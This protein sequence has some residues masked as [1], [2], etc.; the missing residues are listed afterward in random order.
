MTFSRSKDSLGFVLKTGTFVF[1]LVVATKV[2]NFFKKILIG[3]LFGIS[4]Q[5]DSFFAAS[6]LPYYVAVFFEGVIYLGVIP[7]FGKA[8]AEEGE[9]GAKRLVGEILPWIVLLTGGLVLGACLGAPWLVREIVPGFRTGSQTLTQNLFPVMSL[10][11]I[12][13][14][15]SSFFQ[16][17][18]SFFGNYLMAASSGLTDSLTMMGITLVT[19]SIWGIYGAAWG[20]VA[21]ALAAFSLQAFFL[22]RSGKIFPI[23]MTLRRDPILKLSKIL[24][25]LGIIWVFQ[26]I[27]LVILNRFGSGMWQ[28]TISAISISLGIMIVPTGLVSQTVLIS[29]F[30]SLVKDAGEVSNGNARETFF[31]TL[32]AAFFVLVPAGFRLSALAKPFAFLFFSGAGEGA[33]G[34]RRISNSLFYLGWSAFAFYADLFMTQSLITLRKTL[35]AI[36]LCATRAC[37]TYGFCYF[38]SYVW[39]YQGLALSFSLGLAVNLFVLFPLFFRMTPL[40]GMWGALVRYCLKLLLAASPLLVCGWFLKSGCGLSGMV[41]RKAPAFGILAGVSFLGILLYL[42]ALY[43]MRLRELHSV[44]G[45]FKRRWAQKK[46]WITDTGDV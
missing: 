46:W 42:L 7:L 20:S 25:P 9:E 13:I 27:P 33:E 41:S 10:V 23:K 31:Q 14:T 3:N 19:F 1:A 4:W 12:F 45:E 11:I 37:L 40:K 2:F 21:G 34:M 35:P 36:F 22:K 16:S 18:N 8:L 44:L 29:V 43:G 38:L 5:A 24:V 26:M 15:L 17:L 6:Y 30:P 39:D 32:K 28:G